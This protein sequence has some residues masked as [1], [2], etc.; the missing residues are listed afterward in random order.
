M[1]NTLSPSGTLSHPLPPR[2]APGSYF[3]ALLLRMRLP[4]SHSFREKITKSDFNSPPHSCMIALSPYNLI[5]D[6]PLPVLRSLFSS[7]FQPFVP[8]FVS[9]KQMPPARAQSHF[10]IPNPKFLP[11][12]VLPFVPFVPLCLILF[13]PQ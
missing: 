5:T 3:E 11:S 6:F 2:L 1:L 12:L 7:P 10:L 13:L 9:R 8:P 4:P